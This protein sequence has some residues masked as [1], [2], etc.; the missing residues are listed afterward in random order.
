MTS[1]ETYVAS[2]DDY[3]GIGSS[4]HCPYFVQPFG[5]NA[6]KNAVVSDVDSQHVEASRT[7][8]RLNA[9]LHC[10]KV[11]VAV[12]E[13]DNPDSLARVKELCQ[14]NEMRFHIVGKRHDQ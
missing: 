13:L 2:F 12:S 9:V 7:E 1:R 6:H 8:W 4:Q 14:V 10:K 5:K 3:V 11:R